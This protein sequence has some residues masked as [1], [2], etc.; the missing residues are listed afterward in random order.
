[1]SGGGG[2][3]GGGLGGGGEGGGGVGLGGGGLGGGG[4]GGGGNGGGGDGGGASYVVTSTTSL[5]LPYFSKKY[6]VTPGLS[7]EN[8]IICIL[9]PFSTPNSNDSDLLFTSK[10][11]RSEPVIKDVKY[12]WTTTFSP[13]PVTI[14]GSV[15]IETCVFTGR[16]MCT[17]SSKATAVMSGGGAEGGGDGGGDGERGV[18]D[19]AHVTAS[20]GE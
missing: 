9:S 15:G 3:G 20:S 2:E 1:M 8:T 16:K 7:E 12:A 5:C 10:V 11:M 17:P 14:S 19:A 6:S 18:C 4:D 13:R